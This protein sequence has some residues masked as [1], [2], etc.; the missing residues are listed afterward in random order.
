MEREEF[1]RETSCLS[2]AQ[3][4]PRP[5]PGVS[6]ASGQS[7]VGRQ[8]GEERRTQ[9]CRDRKRGLGQGQGWPL[10]SGLFAP[11]S[12]FLHVRISSHSSWYSEG[13]KWGILQPGCSLETPRRLVKILLS[14]PRL[15]PVKPEGFGGVG[16]REGGTG[17]GA[18]ALGLSK[19]PSGIPNSKRQ[20]LLQ[21]NSNYEDCC[22][23]GF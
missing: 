7:V 1:S 22:A 20:P 14:G 6:K 21:M 15:R 5:R 8:V 10:L 12:K 17:R 19:P 18:W 13:T 2:S 4:A 11:C 23:A 9:R 3:P 16:D